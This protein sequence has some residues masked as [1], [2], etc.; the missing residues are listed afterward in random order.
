MLARQLAISQR[1]GEVQERLICPDGT[2]PPIGRSIT[3]RFGAFQL[4]AQLAL[5]QDLPPSL[6]PAQVRSALTAVIRRV[7]EAPGVFDAQG[8][9]RLGLYGAQP[10]LA[11]AYI[12]TG[13]L[14]LNTTVFLPLGLAA[15]D[16][17]WT[18][19]PADWT[20]KRIWAGE[21]VPADSALKLPP[22]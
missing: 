17:F 6:N 4:L 8:W 16:P 13:S 22:A 10:D 19:P 1:Y 7:M 11:E 14:Y 20:S 9:L 15:D 12:S 3:Y 2:F 5:M 21:S 18:L